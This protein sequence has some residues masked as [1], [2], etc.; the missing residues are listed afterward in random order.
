MRTKS[1]ILKFILT[2]ILVIMYV[3]RHGI[4]KCQKKPGINVSYLSN[5]TEKAFS[6]QGCAKDLMRIEDIL[7]YTDKSPY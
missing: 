3:S 4:S 6:I 2:F 7:H 1:L 5:K